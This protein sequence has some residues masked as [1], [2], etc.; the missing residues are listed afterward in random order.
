LHNREEW[1][2]LTD[3][4]R[5]VAR[6]FKQQWAKQMG[7]ELSLSQLRL[8]GLL[9]DGHLRKPTDMADA[10]YVTP[11][12]MTGMADKLIE[13]GLVRRVRAE[14]DRRIWYLQLT[15]RGNERFDSVQKKQSNIIETLFQGVPAEDIAHVRRIFQTI[16]QN[17]KDSD[18]G[19]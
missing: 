2:E 16:L 8:L 19:Q 12:A 18:P 10:L 6:S 5:H 3:L 15:D 1:V 14:N 13:M 9:R 7:D 4:F 11:G 17:I